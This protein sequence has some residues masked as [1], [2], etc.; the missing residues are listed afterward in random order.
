MD[1][2]PRALPLVEP[3]LRLRRALLIGVAGGLAAGMALPWLRLPLPPGA[4]HEVGYPGTAGGAAILSMTMTCMMVQGAIAA[5]VALTIPR[6]SI[7]HAIFAAFVAGWILAV[8]EVLQLLAM[9]AAIGTALELVLAPVVFGGALLALVAA[10][11]VAVLRMP[12]DTVFARRLR[13][14]TP[15]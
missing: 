8:A 14:R 12:A 9:G 7:P 10:V 13:V 4:L 5:L 3:P 6:L 2:A 1:A 11:V 15:S